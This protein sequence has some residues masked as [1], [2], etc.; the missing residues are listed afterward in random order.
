MWNIPILLFV[1]VVFNTAKIGGPYWNT[2]SESLFLESLFLEYTLL[3]EA[4]RLK[5]LTVRLK[6]SAVRLKIY[7]WSH[8]C[9]QSQK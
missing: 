4:M 6:I 7:T 5:F 8:K 1:F 2:K 3:F 9:S